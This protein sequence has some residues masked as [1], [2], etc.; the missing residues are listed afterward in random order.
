MALKLPDQKKAVLLPGPGFQALAMAFLHAP[1][2]RVDRDIIAGI[3][4]DSVRH[5]HEAS[6][7][8]SGPQVRVIS[9]GTNYPKVTPQDFYAKSYINMPNLKDLL[10]TQMPEL[11]STF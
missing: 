4:V 1:S 3:Q 6:S 11:G 8:E 7:R 2:P 5:G 9:E 10:L